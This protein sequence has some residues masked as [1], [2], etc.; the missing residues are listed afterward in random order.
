MEI[1]N[2]TIIITGGS[3][4][5]GLEMCKQFM[6]NGNVVIACSRSLDKLEKAKKQLPNLIV[7]QCDIA[8]E[9]H[10]RNFTSWIKTNYPKANVLINNAAVVSTGSF[11]DDDFILD[12]L[13][14]EVTINF[15]APIRLVKLLYPI[16]ITNNN[17]KIINVTTGLIYVPRAHYTFYNATKAALHS[18]TQVL[19]HQSANKQ[20]QVIEVMFPAVDTPWHNGN[21][22]KIAISPEKAVTEMIKGIN[23][24]KTE[25]R[26]SK[27]K[28]L[29][30][31]S[32]IV[33]QFAFKK[34]NSIS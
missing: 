8:D 6:D 30:F 20:L 26:V 4:G 14:Q 9:N 28:L 34:I 1:S 31:L 7:Y 21:P 19:R 5:I 32:R 11:I 24:N 2:S 29:Y 13:Q 15:I 23:S 3:S 25:I 10:C 17:P 12:K 18:F 27:V 16:L 33:P 22:L